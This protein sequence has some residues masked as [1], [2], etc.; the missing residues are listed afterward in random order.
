MTDRAHHLTHRAASPAPRH[1]T[2]AMTDAP[3]PP[4]S[5]PPDGPDRV[6]FALITPTGGLLTRTADGRAVPDEWGIPYQE[7]LWAAVAAAVDPH[8]RLVNGLALDAGM[9]AKIADVSD[10]VAATMPELY[11]PNPPAWAMLT[12]LGA[13][14][15]RWHGAVAITG[16]EDDDGITAA[17]TEH[18]LALIAEAHRQAL[19]PHR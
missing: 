12:A 11:P 3:P 7:T 13:P 5:S 17:L 19:R 4:A 16:T 2:P 18:Q 8:R 15:G 6:T 10:A 9:R 14:P 1:A